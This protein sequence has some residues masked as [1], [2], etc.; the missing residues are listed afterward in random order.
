MVLFFLSSF[1][2]KE[3]V[4]IICTIHISKEWT[5][6][7][8]E[9][10]NLNVC[11]DKE[12]SCNNPTVPLSVCSPSCFSRQPFL[13]STQPVNLS[14]TWRVAIY[15]HYN[16]CMHPVLQ[17]FTVKLII[18][19]VW[20]NTEEMFKFRS[21]QSNNYKVAPW[22]MFTHNKEMAVPLLSSP[23]IFFC[24]YFHTC[25]YLFDY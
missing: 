14:V 13:M 8:T 21:S 25:Y 3:L 20:W 11:E 15:T 1:I 23:F 16:M 24:S 7:T 19:T 18:I 5:R 4:I 2:L 22:E 17:A 6:P 12:L 10:Q 9:Y